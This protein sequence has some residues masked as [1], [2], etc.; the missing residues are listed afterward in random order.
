MKTHYSLWGSWDLIECKVV[1]EWI[2]Y[3]NGP[4]D[5]CPNPRYVW[6]PVPQIVFKEFP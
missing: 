6:F 4:L 2:V 1:A 5:K 3:G